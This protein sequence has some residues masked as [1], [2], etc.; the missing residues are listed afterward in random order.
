[1][2]PAAAAFMVLLSCAP[3]SLDCKEV[4]HEQVFASV[5]DCRE[6]LPMVLDRLDTPERPVIGRCQTGEPIPLPGIDP[7]ITGSVASAPGRTMP[8]AV[9]TG[10]TTVVTVTRLGP[11]GPQTEEFKVP[12]AR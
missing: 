4:R 9:P 8:T 3:N 5:G 11:G 2:E 1:M 7:I 10:E 6:A 12:V